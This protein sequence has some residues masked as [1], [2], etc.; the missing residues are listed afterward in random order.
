MKT[1]TIIVKLDEET[2]RIL[3]SEAVLAA[4]KL[5]DFASKVI[6]QALVNNKVFT[7]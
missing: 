7:K 3:K 2:H 6:K 1:K 4:Q 5:P